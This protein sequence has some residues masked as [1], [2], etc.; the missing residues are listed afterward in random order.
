MK[1]ICRVLYMVLAEDCN[2]GQYCI[3]H[4]CTRQGAVYEHKDRQ[5]CVNHLAAIVAFC[6]TAE[7]MLRRREGEKLESKGCNR[8]TG[9]PEGGNPHG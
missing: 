3:L 9:E 8:Y 5:D 6:D 4:G 2:T 7:M 1:Y